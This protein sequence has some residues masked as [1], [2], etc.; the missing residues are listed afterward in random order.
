L[1]D[2]DWGGHH[3]KVCVAKQFWWSADVEDAIRKVL[4]RNFRD[5]GVNVVFEDG[6]NSAGQIVYADGNVFEPNEP[7]WP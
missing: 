1:I 5:W 7:R 3:H 6:S 4:A 2:D